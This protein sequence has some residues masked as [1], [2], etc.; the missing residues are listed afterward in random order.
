MSIRVPVQVVNTFVNPHL[1]VEKPE[2]KPA[3]MA[4][5]N[6]RMAGLRHPYSLYFAHA[7]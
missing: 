3:V 2:E 7:G 6:D 5:S 1:T 4:S